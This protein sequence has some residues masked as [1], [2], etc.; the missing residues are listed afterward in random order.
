MN[1]GSDSLGKSNNL[2][3]S[4]VCR[5]HF[6]F[7]FIVNPD[8]DPIIEYALRVH[9]MLFDFGREQWL[10]ADELDYMTWWRT[11]DELLLQVDL[12][13]DDMDVN[14]LKKCFHLRLEDV[15][16][17]LLEHCGCRTTVQIPVSSDLAITTILVVIIVTSVN[18]DM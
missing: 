1:I 2:G 18:E 11:V 5:I 17:Y 4:S 3:V 9:K 13:I 6:G 14:I 16:I 8:S 12:S 10:V 7:G 15:I